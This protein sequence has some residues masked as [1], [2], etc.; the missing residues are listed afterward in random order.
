[1]SN[2]DSIV[3]KLGTIIRINASENDE[4]HENIF[5]FVSSI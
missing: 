2:K 3:L 1:M 4:L 5:E